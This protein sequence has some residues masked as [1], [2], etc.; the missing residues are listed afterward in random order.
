MFKII[1]VIM[2]EKIKNIVMCALVI[3]NSAHASMKNI[4]FSQ[5]QLQQNLT[6]SK[7][8]RHEDA[9]IPRIILVVHKQ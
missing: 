3:L 6:T 2:L 8:N 7:T 9:F 4:C 1:A 5:T